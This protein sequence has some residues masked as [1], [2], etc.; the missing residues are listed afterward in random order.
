VAENVVGH[1]QIR[2]ENVTK[3]YYGE[4]VEN[5]GCF[6]ADGWLHAE[7]DAAKFR[8]VRRRIQGEI[9]VRTDALV[10]LSAS[11]SRRRPA[12]N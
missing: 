3:G 11:L 4:P 8:E 9:G 2:G 12:A 1:L 7:R 6:S 5:V 10:P